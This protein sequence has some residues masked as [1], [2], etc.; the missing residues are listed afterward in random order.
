[1]LN[2]IESRVANPVK[3]ADWSE[4]E[5]GQGV[6]CGCCGWS[7]RLGQCA[8]EASNRARIYDCVQCGMTL[9]ARVYPAVIEYSLTARQEWRRSHLIAA[10]F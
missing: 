9:V 7:G 10:N 3:V 2:L 8:R 5:E 1:M 6:V 4:V